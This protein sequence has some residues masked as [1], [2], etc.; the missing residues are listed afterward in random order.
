MNN[1][2]SSAMLI[3][4]LGCSV[5]PKKGER[6]FIKDNAVE[7]NDSALPPH[8]LK[9]LAKKKI[10]LLGENHGTKEVPEY[11]KQLINELAQN[12]RVIL[13]LEFPMEA[14]AAIDDFVSTGDYQALKKMRFF[15]DSQQHSGR[16]SKAMIEFI[17]DL[18]RNKNITFFCYD[19]PM[20]Y[21]GKNR[22]TEMAKNILEK[23]NTNRNLFITLTGN[24]HSRL[25][26]G[27]P[28][29]PNYPTMGSEILKMSDQHSLD[30]TTNILF[31]HS[32]GSAWQCR[33]ET[34]ESIKCDSYKFEPS[35]SPYATQTNFAKYFLKEK[36][37][38]H[39]HY[40]TVFIRNISSSKPIF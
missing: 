25:E 28:W 34:D 31:R 10:I 15:T 24:L 4:I 21:S 2:V 36:Q 30:N 11:T 37:I 40:N 20:D 14:Q 39:G 13:G 16:A 22:D 8:I 6:N 3:F 27:V 18:R 7:V 9:Q 17:N 35:K 38:D 32:Q 33:Q 19:V 5:N 23:L 26:P 1:L 12:S 29:D